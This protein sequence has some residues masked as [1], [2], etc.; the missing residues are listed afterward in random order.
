MC[1]QLLLLEQ[2]CC[3]ENPE[4]FLCVLRHARQS[5]VACYW[6]PLGFLL[7]EYLEGAAEKHGGMFPR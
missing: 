6:P 2:G 3:T 7:S 1:G 4:A 5:D